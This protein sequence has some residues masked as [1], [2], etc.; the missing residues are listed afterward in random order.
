MPWN[1]LTISDIEQTS[2]TRVVIH[3][4]SAGVYAPTAEER[5]YLH[6]L[7]WGPSYDDPG[8]LGAEEVTVLGPAPDTAEVFLILNGIDGR[9][10]PV[11]RTDHPL[12]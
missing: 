2:P 4:R 11:G 9:W 5:A 12:T 3:R 6:P 1:L 7:L 10:L 8:P